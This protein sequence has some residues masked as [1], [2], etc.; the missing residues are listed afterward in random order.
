[1]NSM[2]DRHLNWPHCYNA[3]DLGGL[4][5]GGR[6]ETRWGAVIRSDVL[7][8][9]T[10]EGQEALLAYGVRTIIDLRSP[11]EAVEAPS[12]FAADERITYL[13]LPLETFEP[14]VGALIGQATTRG[15]IYGI[16][17]DHYT[18]E[19][20]A[21]MR[22]IAQAQPSGIVIHCHAGKDRTAIISALLL[23]LVGVPVEE[24]AAD[25]AASQVRLWPLYE[26][27]VAEAGGENKLGFWAKPSTT[28]EMMIEMLA[29]LDAD[30][31]GVA[32]YLSAAGLTAGELDR[33]RQRL[34]AP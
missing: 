10:E 13:N 21:V 1:M 23:R 29:H 5:I 20:A 11:R 14:H 7:N 16:I 12:I 27:A 19:M 22:A 6:K 33:L 28:E 32:S 24:V 17:L 3:R 26:K 15:E 25:Y 8:R 18:D 9:L 31:G 2:P 30:Y 34:I 4:P